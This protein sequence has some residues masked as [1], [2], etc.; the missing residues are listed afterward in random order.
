MNVFAERKVLQ[1]IYSL[2]YIKIDYFNGNA[3]MYEQMTTWYTLDDSYSSLS[4][5][6]GDDDPENSFSSVPYEKGSQFMY[7]IE[8]LLGPESTQ[9]YLR[10]YI[11]EF[12]GMAIDSS[13]LKIFYEEWVV[14][15]M[16]DDATTIL[17]E[18]M[19]DTWVTEPGLAPIPLDF[20]TEA[21]QRGQNLA[22]EYVALAV[23]KET[24]AEISRSFSS[25]SNHQEYF[26]YYGSQKLAFV[27]E[28][29]NLGGEV[30]AELLAH[31]D[32]DL[33]ITLGEI[34]PH[35]KNE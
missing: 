4:P 20:Y 3:T 19:W 22:R 10:D 5:D 27:Q 33:N 29:S 25:P 23:L 2:D 7:Y 16:G 14:A 9:M 24:D 32:G 11:M 34:N 15:N 13:E 17:E 28:L 6:I 21:V 30:T 8:T 26:E 1:S 35:T 31:I 18:T 12:H